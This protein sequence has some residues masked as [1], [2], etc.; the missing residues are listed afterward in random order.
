L[1][2]AEHA[3]SDD[4]SDT[5]WPTIAA[6][7]ARLET[8]TGSPVVRLNRAVAVGESEGPQA[9]LNLIDGL[10]HALAGNHR[11]HAVRADLARRAGKISLAR[12]AYQ[13]ALKLCTNEVEQQYLAH[14]LTTLNT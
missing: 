6:L 10:D 11:L 2:A 9:G 14:R 13:A 8:L 7:Y 1:I 4:A 5:R 3:G 12:T